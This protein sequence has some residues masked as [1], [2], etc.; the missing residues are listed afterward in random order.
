[1]DSMTNYLINVNFAAYGAEPTSTKIEQIKLALGGI[2]KETQPATQKMDDFHRALSRVVVVAP[3]WMAFRAT[4]QQTM[5]FIKDG[6]QY[7][8]DIEEAM[9]NVTATLQEMGEA[10]KINVAA[11]AE[12]FHNLSIESGKSEAVIANVFATTNRILQDRNKSM[13]ATAEAT[14]LSIETGADAAKIAETMAFLYKLQGDSLKGLTTDTQKFQEISAL[15]YATAAKTPGGITKLESDIRSFSA[16]MNITDFGLENTIRLFGALE[17]SG[18]SNAM[19]LRTGLLKALVN[20]DDAAKM[21]GISFS[22]NT[23]S[24]EKFAKILGTLGIALRTPGDKSGLLNIIQSIFGGTIRGGMG[25]ASLAKDLTAFQEAFAGKGVSE[26]ERYLQQKQLEE[27]TSGAKHQIE[28]FQILRKDLAATFMTGVLGG[29][30]FASSIKNLTEDL[31]ILEP[32]ISKIGMGIHFLFTQQEGKFF[33][34]PFGAINRMAYEFDKITESNKE[35]IDLNTRVSMALRG[36]LPLEDSIATLKEVQ[37]GK[38]MVGRGQH[39]RIIKQLQDE[40]K[41]LTEQGKV[42]DANNKKE[43]LRVLLG[44]QQAEAMEDL[45]LQY[46]KAK[47]EERP[48]LKR[49]IE[50]TQMTEENQMFAFATSKTDRALL[51][52]MTS[53]LTDAVK[54]AMAGT[55]A[56][57]QGIYTGGRTSPWLNPPTGGGL[58]NN[59]VTNIGANQIS[60]NIDLTGAAMP[61]ADEMATL[62]NNATKIELLRDEEFQRAFGKK[63]I[64]VL[65]GGK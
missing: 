30:D 16:T 58:V 47:P 56:M 42:Q 5:A 41:L 18:V 10:G 19:A 35:Q 27:V 20:A 9:H 63:I 14:K 15:L 43:E 44:K 23:S 65:P 13:I 59:A 62:I 61:T 51:L 22:A 38:L 45:L 28:V 6:V 25:L 60:V 24:A 57:E 64:N 17:A 33:V 11:L 54:G 36:Q 39:D 12:E 32:T 3:I 1:M 29:K 26:K 34:G 50:L 46:E 8:L 48:A 52:E 49:K 53:K 21:L 4:I 37:N 55:I 31:K 40:I 2:T 7:M